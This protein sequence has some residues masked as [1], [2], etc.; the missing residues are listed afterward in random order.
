MA[1]TFALAGTAG[2]PYSCVAR[3]PHAFSFASTGTARA[4]SQGWLMP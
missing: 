3:A 2:C 4:T 1:F